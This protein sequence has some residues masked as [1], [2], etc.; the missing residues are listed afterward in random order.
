MTDFAKSLFEDPNPSR[1]LFQ[2]P[3]VGLAQPNRDFSSAWGPGTDR[4]ARPDPARYIHRKTAA[5]FDARGRQIRQ[6]SIGR[7]RPR[8]H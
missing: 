7:T 3:V 5:L 4:R 6:G 2:E 8:I 1:E